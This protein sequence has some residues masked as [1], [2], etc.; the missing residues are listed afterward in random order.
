[1]VYFFTNLDIYVSANDDNVV[2][3]DPMNKGG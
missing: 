2:Y 3:R 1:M